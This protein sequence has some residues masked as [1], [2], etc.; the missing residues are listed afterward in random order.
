MKG[1]KSLPVIAVFLLLL[2]G[3]QGNPLPSG[4]EEETLLEAGQ[5]VVL[6]VVDGDYEA[7]Y[8]AFRPDVA[9]TMTSGDIEE[10]VLRQL[11]GA[12][13]YREITDRMATGQ[14]SQGERYGVAVFYCSY[15]RDKVLFRVAFDPQMSLIGLEVKRQ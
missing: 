4:M 8:A 2:A 3:C 10:L 1:W 14:S 9:Q 12:G 7:I 5:E 6:Q 11:D 13:E 15:T